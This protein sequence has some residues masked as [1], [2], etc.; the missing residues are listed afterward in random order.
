MRKPRFK[1]ITNV[2]KAV[3]EVFVILL[4]P[5]VFLYLA[6]F[7]FNYLLKLYF[8]TIPIAIVFFTLSIISLALTIAIIVHLIRRIKK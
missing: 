5:F 8:L 2:K 4:I 3:I 7:M 6:G 1:Y